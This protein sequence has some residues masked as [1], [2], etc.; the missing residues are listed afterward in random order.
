MRGLTFAYTNFVS[1]I[2]ICI[3]SAG[4]QFGLIGLGPE[5]AFTLLLVVRAVVV[6][7]VVV[8]I[9]LE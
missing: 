4:L 9:S 1:S 7:R 6:V 8:V 2:C 5:F 3:H